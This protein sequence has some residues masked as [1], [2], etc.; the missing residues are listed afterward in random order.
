MYIVLEA[1]VVFSGLQHLLECV[2]EFPL[3]DGF[4]YWLTFLP[5]CVYYLG[6]RSC[7]PGLQHL[8]EC[9]LEYGVQS[10]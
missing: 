9:G 5:L 6:G 10:I 3:G 2:L 8:L 1:V 7:L 4:G